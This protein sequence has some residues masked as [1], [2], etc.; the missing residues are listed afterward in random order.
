MAE[1]GGR[2][3]SGSTLAE[4][5]HED[6]WLDEAQRFLSGNARLPFL[7]PQKDLLWIPTTEEVFVIPSFLPI[8]FHP[9]IVR[10]IRCDNN[11]TISWP[12]NNSRWIWVDSAKIARLNAN[13]VFC[14]L[15]MASRQRIS[16]TG[17]LGPMR[18]WCL[19]SELESPFRCRFVPFYCFTITIRNWF[20]NILK[21]I[22]LGTVHLFP[23]KLQVILRSHCRI[24]LTFTNSSLLI[25]QNSAS[26]K[27]LLTLEDWIVGSGGK[28]NGPILLPVNGRNAR[29]SIFFLLN[30]SFGQALAGEQLQGFNRSLSPT[31]NKPMELHFFVNPRINT[32]L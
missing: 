18:V 10:L 8:P 16:T 14:C 4:E 19:L 27:T 2:E 5:I 28:R 29:T 11:G 25:E 7:V 21:S 30:P 3:R 26:G 23:V 1:A 32:K 22:I 24:P 13:S 31:A 6:T 9:L 17:R 15:Q 12:D 20:W